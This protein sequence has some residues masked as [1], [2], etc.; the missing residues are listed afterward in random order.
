MQNHTGRG[1][2]IP[3]AK[4]VLRHMLMGLAHAHKRGVVH[5]AQFVNQP[6]TNYITPLD[7][8]APESILQGPWDE[9][10]DIWIFG[11]LIFEFLTSATLFTL[12]SDECRPE[13]FVLYQM[14]VFTGERFS[15]DQLRESDIEVALS[16]F[17]P[18]TTF[19]RK[20]PKLYRQ[21]IKDFVKTYGTTT[22]Q[23]RQGA[24][25]LIERCLRLNSRDRPSAEDLLDDPWL[26]SQATKRSDLANDQYFHGDRQENMHTQRRSRANGWITSPS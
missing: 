19:L 8:R 6:V 16:F 1:L 4:R 25:A 15:A 13:E 7:L 9:K 3:L 22:E 5:T 21:H 20:L 12:K 26:N 14:M 10:V 17:D 18:S 24:A 23:E 11:C 2:P